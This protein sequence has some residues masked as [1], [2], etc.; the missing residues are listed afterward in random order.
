MFRSQMLVTTSTIT[1]TSNGCYGNNGILNG[2]GAM[3]GH[4]YPSS[5]GSLFSNNRYALVR[6]ASSLPNN[7][8][9]ANN[10]VYIAPSSSRTQMLRINGVGKS[11]WNRVG[12]PLAFSG[13]NRNEVFRAQ[14]KAR[15]IGGAAPPKKGLVK[16]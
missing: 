13:I 9:Y 4:F 2:K 7:T 1:P 8:K 3:P 12:G 14:V 6:T 5:Q 16:N 15:R 11:S 10:P